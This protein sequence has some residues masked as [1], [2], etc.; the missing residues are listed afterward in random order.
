MLHCHSH[1][2]KTK[3]L[4]R[5]CKNW[6]FACFPLLQNFCGNNNLRIDQSVKSN[7]VRHL[8]ELQNTFLLYFPKGMFNCD[9]VRNPFSCST[10]P[11]TGK[12][13]KEFIKLLSDGNL[14]L[15]FT[16]H[17][18]SKFWL[19]VQEEYPT[20]PREALKIQETL[21]FRNNLPM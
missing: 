18:S 19:S 13:M 1:H 10:A 2:T 17:L 20:L 12:T 8:Q 6:R 7:I 9:W 3:I 5:K 15:Q 16:S 4:V 11:F 21:V 14:K